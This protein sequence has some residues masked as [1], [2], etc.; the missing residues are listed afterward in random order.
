MKE[1]QPPKWQLKTL[2]GRRV[3]TTEYQWGNANY[4]HDCAD[5]GREATMLCVEINEHWSVPQPDLRKFWFWCGVCQ[6]GG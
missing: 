6:V 4:E 3:W 5:C 2:H 1:P